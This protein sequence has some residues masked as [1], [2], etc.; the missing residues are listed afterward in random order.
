MLQALGLREWRITLS[1]LS[2]DSLTGTKYWRLQFVV[3]VDSSSKGEDADVGRDPQRWL[4][5]K[6]QQQQQELQLLLL[7]LPQQLQQQP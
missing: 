6:Y 2:A 1:S 4:D 3:L 5:G 7:H